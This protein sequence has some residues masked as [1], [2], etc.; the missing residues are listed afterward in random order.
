MSSF[1]CTCAIRCA[2]LGRIYTI[3]YVLIHM[4]KTGKLEFYH[5]IHLYHEPTACLGRY[6]CFEILCYYAGNCDLIKKVSFK[7]VNVKEK[8]RKESISHF[9][10]IM[11]S[12]H[13]CLIIIS[14]YMYAVSIVMKR[15]MKFA[16]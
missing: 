1:S 8:I 6:K 7:N 15:L 9:I 12:I 3:I 13:T 14:N 10:K 2:K 11:R 4:T 16:S 5:I